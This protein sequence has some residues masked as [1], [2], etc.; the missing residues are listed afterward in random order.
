MGTRIRRAVHA[1][2]FY[3]ED[4]A[5][6]REE[7]GLLLEAAGG[8]AGGEVI[9]GIIAPHAGYIFS[10]PPAAHAYQRLRGRRF[11]RVVVIGPSHY[12]WFDGVA[13]WLGDAFETPL[14]HV[15][16][17]ASL[18]ERLIGKG[19]LIHD[20][21]RAHEPEHSIEVE[22]PFL[23]EVLEPGWML[24]PLLAA[25]QSPGL[26]RSL[27]ERVGEMLRA[28]GQPSLVVASSDL[29]HGEDIQ[30]CLA[31]DRR[32][33]EALGRFDPDAF[34][35]GA[36]QG[37]YQ[38]CGAG[39]IAATMWATQRLGATACEVLTVTN[40]NETCLTASRRVVG[41]LAATLHT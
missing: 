10:G 17:D 16:V 21:P 24:V 38:A 20:E 23:Q 30:E 19:D 1:G 5:T 40:S 31:S 8:I 34:L 26:M 28:D 14:G 27:G 41:Y 12:E 6:L 25:R 36:A 11:A 15:P 4:P 13:T 29:Y 33:A 35:R 18:V 3:G 7:I 22:L 32:C 37:E 2:T 9:Q 39:P